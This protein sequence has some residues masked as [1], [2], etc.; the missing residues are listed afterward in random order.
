M[1]EQSSFWMHLKTL[2]ISDKSKSVP[3]K[4]SHR[5]KALFQPPAPI[6]FL[7]LQPAWAGMTRQ[8]AVENKFLYQT[9]GDFMV[10]LETNSRGSDWELSGLILDAE[11][12]FTI[13]LFGR[14]ILEELSG[15]ED[16]FQFN[17]LEP[18]RYRICFE[19]GGVTFWIKSLT[20]GNEN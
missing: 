2:T 20:I 13:T 14:G 7:T 5:A 12:S 10:Q 16:R 19:Q 9:N 18:G 3:L 4:A 11:G 15:V 8:V 6:Q 17:R 1:F